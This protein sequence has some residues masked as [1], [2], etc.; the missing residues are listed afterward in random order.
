M[1]TRIVAFDSKRESPDDNP[2]YRFAPQLIEQQGR[3]L[4]IVLGKRLCDAA[5][6]KL[7]G[8][9]RDA[10][11]A[12]L[13]RL[14]RSSCAKQEGY[15]SPQHPV[16]EVVLRMLLAAK[17]NSLTLTEIHDQALDLWTHSPVPR[18]ISRESLRRVLDH[19]SSHGIAPAK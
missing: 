5:K 2:S 14:F 10:S 8:D 18:H 16:V 11:Y 17:A 13:R 15:L 19:S 1:T 9:L 4:G 7:K 3:P 12:E 6:A